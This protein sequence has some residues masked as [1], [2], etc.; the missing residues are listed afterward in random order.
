[1]KSWTQRTLLGLFGASL[2]MGALTA[3]GH[4]YE[5]HAWNATPEE[6]A[7]HRDR[8]VDRVA[9]KLE[10]DAQQKAKLAVLAD[11]LQE[12][13]T[14]LVGATPDPRTQ[15]RSLVAA[16]KFDRA[17]AQALVTEKTAAVTARSPE[18]IA[19]LGDFYDS[20]NPTQQARVREYME[21]RRGW[22]HRS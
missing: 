3:C 9:S 7:R 14:A 8:M 2:A 13:R 6:R 20:L 19:A 15:L 18:L 21:R 17:R 11:K 1:M 16:E 22:W 4:R 5:H 10:L 12:Q